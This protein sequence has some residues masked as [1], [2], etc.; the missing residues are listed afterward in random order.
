[1][2]SVLVSLH[3]VYEKAIEV[4]SILSVLRKNILNFIFIDIKKIYKLYI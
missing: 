4:V 1:M 3:D 2:V